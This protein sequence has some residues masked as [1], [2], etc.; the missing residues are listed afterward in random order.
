MKIKNSLNFIKFA[1]LGMFLVQNETLFLFHF[2]NQMLKNRKT[3]KE[4]ENIL[5]LMKSNNLFES[6]K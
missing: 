3:E 6:F 5:N 2:V 1:L 4:K